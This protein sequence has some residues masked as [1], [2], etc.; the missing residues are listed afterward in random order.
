M[1]RNEG[2]EGSTAW[3]L[4]TLT[5]SAERLY[6]NMQSTSRAV[7]LTGNTGNA[8]NPGFECLDSP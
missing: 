8:S 1:V 7:A 2:P 5:R 3:G 6:D 4:P